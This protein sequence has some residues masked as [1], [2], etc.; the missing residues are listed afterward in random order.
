MWGKGEACKIVC[1]QP[2]CI[3]ATSVAERICYERGGNVG[4]KIRLESKGGRNSSIVF[5]TNGILL[6][7]LISEGAGRLK[8]KA[9]RNLQSERFL[10]LLTLSWY[11]EIFVSSFAAAAYLKSINFPKDEKN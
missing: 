10:A 4:Y 2:R 7:V 5:C 6:R 3:S 11:E 9:E 8:Q 1:T